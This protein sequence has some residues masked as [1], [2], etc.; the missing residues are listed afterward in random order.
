MGKKE[1]FCIEVGK[2]AFEKVIDD[3]ELVCA[4]PLNL[5]NKKDFVG[6]D[7]YWVDDF[8]GL[9]LAKRFNG[10]DERPDDDPDSKPRYFLAEGVAEMA[11]KRRAK[12]D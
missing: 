11:A 6:F 2:D 7:D 1:R 12:A 3:L 9:T 5:Y 4:E 8:T 10:Y